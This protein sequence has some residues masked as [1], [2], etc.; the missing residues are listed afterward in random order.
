MVDFTLTEEQENLREMAHDFAAQEMRPVACEYARDATWPQAVIEKAWE[1]GL[2]KP[3]IP[4]EYGG[5]G[6]SAMD[7]VLTEEEARVGLLGDRYLD[8]VQRAGVGAGA[9][10]ALRADRADLPRDAVRRFGNDR[11]SRLASSPGDCR[12]H[13]R[14]RRRSRAA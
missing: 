6:A 9:A 7:G 5:A 8:L 10:R 3:H 1:V 12:K 2:M 4:E 13:R 14:P 11:E